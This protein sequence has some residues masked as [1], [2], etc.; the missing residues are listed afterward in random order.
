MLQTE[1]WSF[2]RGAGRAVNATIRPST[3]P[4]NSFKLDFHWYDGEPVKL[5]LLMTLEDLRTLS[6]LLLRA[7]GETGS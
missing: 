5:P 2:D 4:P 6:D 1:L 3:V 7:A